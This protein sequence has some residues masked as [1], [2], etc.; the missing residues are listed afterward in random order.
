MY[1]QDIGFIQ[2]SDFLDL[3]RFCPEGK[4]VMDKG[5]RSYLFDL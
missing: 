5:D 4:N 1:N 2:I 3:V